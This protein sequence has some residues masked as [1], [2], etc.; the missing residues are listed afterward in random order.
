MRKLRDCVVVVTGASSGIG[1]ATALA[2]ARCGATVVVAA[3]R[4]LA[5]RQVA[6]ECEGLASL[7]LAVPA[8]VSDEAAVQEVARSAIETF[9]RIDVWVNN[10]AVT[11]FGRLEETPAAASRR[12]IETNLLGCI[13]GARAALACFREQ[14]SGVLINVASVVGK[15]GQPY[16]G[17]YVSSKFGIVGL[18]ESL[19]QEVRD[20]A[21][22]HVCTILAPS[23]DTPLIHQAANYTGRAVKPLRPLHDPD[24]VAAMIVCCAQHPQREV[25]DRFSHLA[26]KLH[27]LMPGIAERVMQAK[28]EREHFDRQPALPTS[29]NLFDPM[30]GWTST[31]GGWKERQSAAWRRMGAVGFAALGLGLLVWWSRPRSL[32]QQWWAGAR[33]LACPTLRGPHR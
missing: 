14:A 33:K 17:A 19:R 13:H 32:R 16:T 23:T 6:R 3:R 7:A 20:V 18:S 26:M 27:E 2:F 21:D 8:D 5:L 4:E 10:A 29:G 28:V 25:A 22:I 11:T 31:R 24:E 15:V 12:V 9:G 1:R 30:A